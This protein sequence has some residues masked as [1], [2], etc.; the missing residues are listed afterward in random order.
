MKLTGM[1]TRIS[2]K[3]NEH[4]EIRGRV[5]EKAFSALGQS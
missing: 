2:E 4:S 3:Q 1:G 5:R